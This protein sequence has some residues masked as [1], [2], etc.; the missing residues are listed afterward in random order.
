MI[1]LDI[2]RI[3]YDCH[4]RT[5]ICEPVSRIHL[6][7]LYDRRSLECTIVHQPIIADLVL[8]DRIDTPT[9]LHHH[10]ELCRLGSWSCTDIEDRLTS[11]WIE[12][13]SWEL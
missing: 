10:G 2:C 7:S 9:V 5:C 3:I 11:L 13:E 4:S 1:E 8:L 12:D 6:D